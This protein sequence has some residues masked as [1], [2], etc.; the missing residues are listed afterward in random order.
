MRSVPGGEHSPGFQG[1]G[2]DHQIGVP[3]WM[4]ALPRQHPQVRRVVEDRIRHR[5][6]AARQFATIRSR[7]IERDTSDRVPKAK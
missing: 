1:R 4:S 5:F 7:V 6:P 3:A 2:G